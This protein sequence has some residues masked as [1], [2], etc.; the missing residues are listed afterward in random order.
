M[1]GERSANTLDK[2]RARLYRR[3]F[4]TAAG[5]GVGI[6]A[7]A[8][9]TALG[10][11]GGGSSS[12]PYDR[13]VPVESGQVT[14]A[15]VI[16]GTLPEPEIPDDPDILDEGE[17]EEVPRG[18]PD[19]G[20]SSG[21]TP[22]PETGTTGSGLTV[23]RTF[24][25]FTT[26]DVVRGIDLDDDG[27]VEDAE[28]FF[29]VPSDNQ[30]AASGDH[31]VTTIN[32]EIGFIAKSTPAAGTDRAGG[33][34]DTDDYITHYRLEDF[35]YDVLNLA[36]GDEDHDG[37]GEPDALQFENTQ[38]FDPRV[39]YDPDSGRFIVA[40]VEFNL[41]DTKPD[42]DGTLDE[43]GDGDATDEKESVDIEDPDDLHGAYLVAVSTTDDPNDP[44]AV[45]RIEPDSAFGLVD[46]P[47][48]GYDGEAVYLSQNFFALPGF[49]FE[50]ATLTV[51][52]KA[53]LTSGRSS[54]TGWE[55]TGLTNPDGSRAFTLQPAAMPTA[56]SEFHLANSRFGNGQ[57]VTVWNVTGQNDLSSA[58]TLEN[59]SVRTA[60]YANAPAAEQDDSNKKIDTLDT[61][62]MNLAF[63]KHTGSLWTAHT[64]TEGYVRWYELDPDQRELVQSAGYQRQH[65][66]T[67]LPTVEAH[68]GSMML[69][70]NICAEQQFAGV[71]V[72]GRKTDHPEGELQDHAS[73][74]PGEVA[75]N[76]DD[77]KGDFGP[78]PEGNVLRW[79]D[80]NG[81]AIDPE[82]GS[83][84]VIGQYA[85][86][87]K[88]TNNGPTESELYGTRI[89]NVTIDS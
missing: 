33:P 78:G 14:H 56:T 31:L 34:S 48:L 23:N 50:G 27:K 77:T 22:E 21:S 32:S 7:G 4:L 5:A 43:N 47:T 52:E 20:A 42:D 58:P 65:W 88:P 80:Y 66:S 54:V 85:K 72:A 9:G 59:W 86:D 74:Q 83:F 36:A 60:P 15:T 13:V 69:V 57:T 46:Y 55:F 26:R 10:Q 44:W 89:A 35:F 67:F 24:D 37:D 25:G 70:Y 76:Y 84:W 8:T 28:K 39:R 17:G 63:D 81:A 2:L 11:P 53:D 16:P 1:S 30:V 3:E 75:Y 41:P 38:V 62:L 12:E 45:Y 51:L 64:T 18:T 87:S 82:D 71:E 49:D 79:G 73:I 68:D 6:A 40:C 61:R 19:G 29:I